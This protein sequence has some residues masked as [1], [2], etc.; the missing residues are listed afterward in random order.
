MAR[1]YQVAGETI[2]MVKGGA[3]LPQLISQFPAE[4]GLCSEQITITPKFI[5]QDIPVDDFGGTIPPEVLWMMS[6]CNI[7]MTLVHYDRDVLM[8]CVQ[9]AMGGGDG[10]FTL[11]LNDGTCGKGGIPLGGGGPMFASGNHLM[12]LNLISTNP[13]DYFWRFKSC[14]LNSTPLE[15]PIGTERSLVTLNWRA[16]PYVPMNSSG[17]INASSGRLWDHDQD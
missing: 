9:E 10:S 3:H 8:I 11:L 2:V 14:Y 6:E 1:Q 5:H 12:S 16:I 15:I 13:D 17:E 4:L 7:N